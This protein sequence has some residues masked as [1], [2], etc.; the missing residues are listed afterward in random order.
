MTG[1]EAIPRD[2]KVKVA[3]GTIVLVGL[4]AGGL[5]YGYSNDVPSVLLLAVFLLALV[6]HHLGRVR[7]MLEYDA[8][9]VEYMDELEAERDESEVDEPAPTVDQ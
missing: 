3:V 8:E 6:G 2:M 9:L 5:W 1:L 7:G 4:G